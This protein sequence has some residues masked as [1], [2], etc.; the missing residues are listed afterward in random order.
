MSERANREKVVK[1]GTWKY[2]GQVTCLV[3]VVY[4]PVRY[5]TGDEWADGP[6]DAHDRE[7]ESYYL[8]YTGLEHP[9]VFAFGGQC[10]DTLDQAMRHAERC[11]EYVQW[12]EVD[13]ISG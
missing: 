12:S 11:V 10:F 2:A 13:E 6:E 3:R 9:D 8:Q 4:S 7:R 5:G 1:T